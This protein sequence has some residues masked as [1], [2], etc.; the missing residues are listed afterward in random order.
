MSRGAI[1]RVVDRVSDALTPH[2]EAIAEK[3]RNAPVHD[4]DESA[5]Y[6][7]GLWAWLWVMVNPTVAWFNV[8][9]SRS[10][11]AFA[12]LI[13]HWSGMMVSDGDDV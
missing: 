11:A 10:Q 13:E 1:Q 12:V 4:I 7:Y 3:A 8:Q 6:Q 5:W 2:C 9:A